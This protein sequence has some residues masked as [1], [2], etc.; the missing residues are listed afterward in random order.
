L[1]RVLQREPVLHSLRAVLHEHRAGGWKAELIAWGPK[2][3]M[4]AEFPRHDFWKGE[5]EDDD[6]ARALIE[7]I[8]ESTV[9]RGYEPS[10]V[11]LT[12]AKSLE[13]FDGP[14]LEKRTRRLGSIAL[15]LRPR[16]WLVLKEHRR[17]KPGEER[18]RRSVLAL[19][20]EGLDGGKLVAQLGPIHFEELAPLQLWADKVLVPRGYLKEGA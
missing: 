12:F 20:G 9:T 16:N 19:R 1:E 5:L 6:G 7:W 3:P 2:V 15:G 8:W 4:K 18:R 10:S 14:R 17:P 13:G 11:E